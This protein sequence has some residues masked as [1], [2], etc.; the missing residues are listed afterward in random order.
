MIAEVVRKID[1]SNFKNS[2]EDDDLHKFYSEI[3]SSGIRNLDPGWIDRQMGFDGTYGAN[4]D[5][6]K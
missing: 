1:Y 2:V 6:H 4:D 3:W 5:N